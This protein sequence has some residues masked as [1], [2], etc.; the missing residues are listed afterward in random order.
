[1]ATFKDS[2]EEAAREEEELLSAPRR[3]NR[4]LQ[5]ALIGLALMLGGYAATNYSPGA[6]E[7]QAETQRRLAELQLLAQQRLE[8]GVNDELPEKL[9]RIAQPGQAYPYQMAGRVAIYGGLFLFVLAAIQMYHSAPPPQKD[10]D[11]NE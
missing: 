10:D 8:A 5:L 7:R 3:G 6:A 1:M 2:R 11:A 4:P 9:H